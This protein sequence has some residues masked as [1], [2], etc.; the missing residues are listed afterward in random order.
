MSFKGR[1]FTLLAVFVVLGLIAAQCG[2]APTPETIT[3]VET[4]VVEKEVQGETVT[5]VETVEVVKEVEV[6]KVVTVEVEK[7]AEAPAKPF[8]GVE[9]NILTFTGPQIAEPQ[10]GRA[11][12]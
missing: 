11:H 7:E 10:I 3:V 9:V 2:P 5:V 1:V 8:E 6:E 12:V 4:V